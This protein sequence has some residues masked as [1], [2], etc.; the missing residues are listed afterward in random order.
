MKTLVLALDTTGLRP[1]CGFTPRVI[2]LGA[3]II[4]DAGSSILRTSGLVIRQDVQH[5]HDV[6]A[7]E[8]L[9]INGFDIPE[10]LAADHDTESAA[11]LLRSGAGT[12]I[13][14]GFNLP[15]IQS[16][17]VSPPWSVQPR[18][19]GMCLMVRASRAAKRKRLSLKQAL[20][21]C[22]KHEHDVDPVLH[23]N[24]TAMKAADAAKVFIALTKEGF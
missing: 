7:A 23:E 19:W 16:F 18:S 3:A 12:V 15:F 4:D 6:H 24:P 21:W 5:L 9:R 14:T 11:A 22:A 8:A 13:V 20:Q 10:I 2:S 1:N 17:L